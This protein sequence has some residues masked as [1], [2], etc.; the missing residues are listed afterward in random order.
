MTADDWIAHLRLAP[1]PEGGYFR[2]GHTAE[3][4][5]DLPDRTGPRPVATAIFYLLKG[6]QHSRLHRLKSDELWHFHLGSALT[7]HRLGRREGY[8]ATKLGAD[9]AAGQHL[10][11]VVRA[12]CWFG[13][14]VDDPAGF[15]LLGCTVAPG[16]DFAD[17]ELANRATLIHQYPQHAALIERL[18]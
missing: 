8:V 12:G 14:T 7:L 10:Q 9:P 6:G 16:F 17:F 2:R 5:L 4:T 13:A 1:H 15:S 18:T 11:I 3:L